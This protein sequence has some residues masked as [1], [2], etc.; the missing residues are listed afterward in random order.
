MPDIFFTPPELSQW[1][2]EE[3]LS[4][5]YG[6]TFQ[7]QGWYQL[8]NNDFA[9][10]LVRYNRLKIH[11]WINQDPREEFEKLLDLPFND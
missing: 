11:T 4:R 2:T 8:S 1:T 7:E 9:L 3:L 5:D 6:I 10:V